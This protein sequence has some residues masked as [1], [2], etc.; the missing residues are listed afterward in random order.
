MT[1]SAHHVLRHFQVRPERLYRPAR[2]AE[3]QALPLGV[4]DGHVVVGIAV[5]PVV[6]ARVE[7][8]VA[9]GVAHVLAGHDEVA[10]GSDAGVG[11]AEA[12]QRPAGDLAGLGR[13]VV[14]LDPLVVV[15]LT[16]GLVG[17]VHQLVDEH[18]PVRLGRGGHGQQEDGEE[19]CADLAHPIVPSGAHL[20]APDPEGALPGF[21]GAAPTARVLHGCQ[22][23]LRAPGG[24]CF[25]GM[26]CN[27]RAEHRPG[28]ALLAARGREQLLAIEGDGQG[29]DPHDSTAA[30]R[31]ANTALGPVAASS[32]R[33]R[34]GQAGVAGCR[35]GGERVLQPA[36]ELCANT[37]GKALDVQRARPVVQGSLRQVQR[38]V[39][40]VGPVKVVPRTR[41]GRAHPR[42]SDELEGTA[43]AIAHC[44][45]RGGG[46]CPS[47]ARTVD[48]GPPGASIAGL[49]ARGGYR[50]RSLG[51]TRALL[52]ML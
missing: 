46:A 36:D 33:T 24:R 34:T 41:G 2:V 4:H 21:A 10:V 23:R 15:G 25:G 22:M 43:V 44:R 32:P 5:A 13:G 48:P 52:G 29:A 47:A 11:Q 17:G 42:Q 14:E 19:S 31:A 16:Q 35:G 49:A 26:R 3:A 20:S 45:D 7:L 9:V 8:A 6:V 37:V 51:S 28:P 40:I 39:G 27:K 30:I 38:H 12:V 18:A 50:G 1:Y